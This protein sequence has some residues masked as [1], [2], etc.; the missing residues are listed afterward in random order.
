MLSIRNAHVFVQNIDKN[1]LIKVDYSRQLIFVTSMYISNK[2]M[3]LL[4]SEIT[5][6]TNYPYV[7]IE[8]V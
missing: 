4:F 7:C 2:T 6:N 1:D 5:L 3:S 8:L